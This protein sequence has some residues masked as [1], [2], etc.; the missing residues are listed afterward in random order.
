MNVEYAWSLVTKWSY[1]IAAMQ[2]ALIA[3][4]IGIQ[5]PNPAPFAVVT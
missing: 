5:D 3:I 4:V 1:Q 2:C